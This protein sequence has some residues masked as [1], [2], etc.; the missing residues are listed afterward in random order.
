[1]NI[2]GVMRNYLRGVL[3]RSVVICAAAVALIGVVLG[4]MVHGTTGAALGAVIGAVS[5]II[6][7]IQLDIMVSKRLSTTPWHIVAFAVGFLT[8]MLMGNITD[9]LLFMRTEGADERSIT[10][11]T[12]STDAAE[13]MQAAG[14]FS[15]FDF[16]FQEVRTSRWILWAFIALDSLIFI[17]AYGLVG[18]RVLT[19][20]LQRVDGKGISNVDRFL[21]WAMALLL[22]VLLFDWIENLS[23]GVLVE[24][25]WGDVSAPA[26]EAAAAASAYQDA[27]TLGATGALSAQEV[28]DAELAAEMAREDLASTGASGLTRSFVW[29]TTAMFWLKWLSLGSAL[30][31]FLADRF[32]SKGQAVDLGERFTWFAETDGKLVE[33]GRRIRP[34]LVSLGALAILLLQPLQ[35]SDLMLSLGDDLGK[36]VYATVMTIWI[37]ITFWSWARYLLKNTPPSKRHQVEDSALI[38]LGVLLAVAGGALKLIFDWHWIVFFPAAALVVIGILGLVCGGDR[39]NTPQRVLLDV[40]RSPSLIGLPSSAPAI[41]KRDRGFALTGGIGLLLLGIATVLVRSARWN[42]L[43]LVPGLMLFLAA[44]VGVAARSRALKEASGASLVPLRSVARTETG[45]NKP[46]DPTDFLPAF[47]GAAAVMVVGTSMLSAA[48]AEALFVFG[49]TGART[50]SL[51]GLFLVALAGVTL[52]A[53]RMHRLGQGAQGRVPLVGSTEMAFVT[54]FVSVIGAGT[55]AFWVWFQPV[56]ASRHAGA[57]ALLLLL[58]AAIAAFSG[59]LVRWVDRIEAPTIFRQ[60]SIFRFPLFGLIG[61]WLIVGQFTLDRANHDIPDPPPITQVASIPEGCEG[62][63]VAQPTVEEAWTSWLE[64]NAIEDPPPPTPTEPDTAETDD[65][66]NTKKQYPV[67]IMAASGGGIRAAWWSAAVMGELIDEPGTACP[68]APPSEFEGRQIFVASGISGG[69]LGLATHQAAVVEPGTILTTGQDRT[70]WVEHRLGIDHLSP[71]LAWF[72]FVEIPQSLL[73]FRTKSDRAAVMEQSWQAPWPVPADHPPDQPFGLDRG[74][75]QTWQTHPQLPI[76]ALNGV[77]VADGCRVLVSVIALNGPG[78]ACTTTAPETSD[79]LPQTYGLGSFLCTEHDIRLST[80]ALLSA[81]FPLISPSGRVGTSWPDDASCQPGDAI[82]VVDGGYRDSNGAETAIDMWH[83]IQ[84]RVNEYNASE[85]APVCLVPVFV[86]IIDDFRLPSPESASSLWPPL[87]GPGQAILAARG[88]QGNAGDRA[89]QTENAFDGQLFTI[90]P[91]RVPPGA[92]PAL[93]WSL[94]ETT[95]QKMTE[96]IT[97]PLRSDSDSDTYVDRSIVDEFTSR[98]EELMATNCSAD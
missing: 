15:L 55:L 94:S 23:V 71:P 80:G 26:S 81:R 36:L 56:E 3:E 84:P 75:Y 44:L 48:L 2:G 95:R 53:K 98:M 35:V 73:G 91:R 83:E 24:S 37:G 72:A 22:A 20:R 21:R 86:Q 8:L 10:W 67:V 59:Q 76:L 69:S 63:T 51:F 25:A 27:L 74:L 30:L 92:H 19:S 93:G 40:D 28:L 14:E 47:V 16:S 6:F 17:A 38:G 50:V 90:R 43:V 61:L 33:G 13:F 5:V 60:F 87:L 52:G 89:M 78:A 96:A 18:L 85:T 57:L 49:S 7:A 34:V 42:W 68:D 4:G 88:T 77:A 97:V 82:E 39:G 58:I 66:E 70:E 65:D 1:M 9:L 11:I 79:A 62:P 54:M 29:I 46:D 31:L 12:K 32:S 41:A 45:H 64:T